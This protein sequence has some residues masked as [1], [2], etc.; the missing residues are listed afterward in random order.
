MKY[1][2]LV[3]THM[4]WIR[5]NEKVEQLK[6]NG[7]EFKTEKAYKIKEEDAM[8]AT[9]ESPDGQVFYFFTGNV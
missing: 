1:W 6:D 9:I 3:Y 7:L 2:F 4:T 5:M 8:D